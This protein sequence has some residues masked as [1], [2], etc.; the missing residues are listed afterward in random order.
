MKVGLITIYQVPNYGS[1]LQ[2]F[3]TQ[4]LLE[5]LGAECDIINYKYPNEWH[6]RHGAN[7]PKG[8]RALIRK[9]F[10]SKKTKN[11]DQFRREY[12]H[13]T[14]CYNNLEELESADWSEYDAFVVGSDQVWNARFVLGDSVFMLSF[15]PEGVPRYSIA[16]SFAL[17]TLP[18]SLRARYY[19]ELSKF[20]AIS[21]RE[22]NGVTI[23]NDELGISKSIEIVLDPTLLLSK[24]DWLNT[25]PRSRFKKRSPYILLYMWTY[26]FE[27]RPY[28]FDVVKYFKQKMNC[29]VIALEGFTRQEQAGGILMEN[30]SSSSVPVFID[31]FANADLVITSSFHGTAFAVNFG[32]PLI[33]IVPDGDA[34]DRQ[35]TLLESIGADNSICHINDECSK[36][37][38][39]YNEKHVHN[40][41]C[42]IRENNISW[43]L[44]QIIG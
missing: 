9:L 6:W 12:F 24:E 43:I 15:V 7:K 11:L 30:R 17:K 1:V 21:V 14:K 27:P 42:A 40:K 10:P 35:S 29:D 4:Q 23:L 36:I 18:D 41:L 20:S 28:I 8:L 39:Y 33:S 16:S 2:A 13:F 25:I 5:S 32:V 37:N 26:A 3:A 44:N 38:P 31:L 22:Q 19:V 34:D